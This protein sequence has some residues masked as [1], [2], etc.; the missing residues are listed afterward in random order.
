M[1]PIKTARLNKRAQVWASRPV[2]L[3]DPYA[4]MRT[5]RKLTKKEA[6]GALM[7]VGTFCY[8]LPADLDRLE[9]ILVNGNVAYAKPGGCGSSGPLGG[10]GWRVERRSVYGQ[11]V[12]ATLTLRDVPIFGGR[13]P[14]FGVIYAAQEGAE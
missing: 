8:R 12:Y 4:Q 1:H 14:A 9:M 5:G 11:V 7:H 6:A 10:G 2:L 13:P 3:P